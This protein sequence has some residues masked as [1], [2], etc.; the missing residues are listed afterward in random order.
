[1]YGELRDVLC[2][3]W[4]LEILHFLAEEGTHNY[5]EIETEFDTSSDIISDRLQHLSS[6]G[7]LI[8]DKKSHK[9]VRYSISPDGKKLLQRL[10]ELQ[11]LLDE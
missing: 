8:R 11:P 5:S 2:R 1:M 9:D 10:S 6:V 4:G 7:L 3:K